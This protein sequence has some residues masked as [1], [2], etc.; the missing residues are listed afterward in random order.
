M[1]ALNLI[2]NISSIVSLLIAIF[3]TSQVISIKNKIKD[4]STNRAKQTENKTL[5]DLAGRDIT[6]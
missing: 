3:L 6:K 4:A 2:G 5:G 1:E